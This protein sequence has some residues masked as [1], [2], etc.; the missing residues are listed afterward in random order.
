MNAREQRLFRELVNDAKIKNGIS[1][2]PP[3]PNIRSLLPV[4]L[5]S[6]ITLKMVWL[7]QFERNR[8]VFGDGKLYRLFVLENKT[9]A[10]IAAELE[11]VE[12]PCCEE[13]SDPP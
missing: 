3:A 1:L 5:A 7:R 9:F 8:P 2:L 4:S 10:G 13:D 12:R 11:A 6:P